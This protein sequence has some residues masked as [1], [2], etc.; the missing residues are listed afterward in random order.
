MLVHGLASKYKTTWAH[1]RE[2]G[3]RYHWVREQL[4]KDMPDARVLG[5]EYPSRWY[6]D[7]VTTSLSEC[8]SQLLRSLIQDR[9]HIGAPEMCR[10]R[11][12][13][14]GRRRDETRLVWW[15]RC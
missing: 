2:D 12:S 5:F 14:L 7:P 15:C 8:A 4:P 10:T 13:N 6:D 3:S 11:V 1:K 9:C